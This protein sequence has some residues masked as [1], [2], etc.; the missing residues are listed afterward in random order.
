MRVIAAFAALLTYT[1]AADE[2]ADPDVHVL[3]NESFDEFVNS[4]KYVLAEFYAPW[5]GHCKAL[6][7]EYAKVATALKTSESE[8][9][10]AKIDATV[11]K[12]IAERF[13]VSG[14]PSLF[15]FVDGEKREYTGGRTE[16]E[17][18]A[19]INR[20]TSDPY[21][22]GDDIPETGTKALVLL[23][24]HK[25]LDEFVKL[26]DEMGDD[27][28]FHYLHVADSVAPQVSVQ[29]KGEDVIEASKS[30]MEDL[31]AFINAN[32]LAKFGALDG[33]TYQKYMGSGKGLVWVMLPLES[34][35]DLAAK[36]DEIRPAF[37]ELAGKLPDFKFVYID[38]IM[39]AKAIEGMFGVS[40]FPAVVVHKKAG[41]KKKFVLQGDDAVNPSKVHSFV[42]DVVAGK[43]SAVLKSEDAPEDDDHPVKTIVGSTMEKE[44][45]QDK[46]ILFEVYAPWCGH[47]KK[48]APELDK[49]AS[50]I[51]AD[52]LEDLIRITKMD[53]TANDSPLESIT[54]EGFPTMYYIK[55]GTGKAVPFS[56]GRDAKSIWKWIKSNHSKSGELTERVSAAKAAKEAT[57]E[58]VEEG[59]D[60]L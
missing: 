2:V 9:K 37:T 31:K 38:T 6:A 56:G 41:D 46:D 7:P 40:A 58:K 54:W 5:C 59:K 16:P 39:F 55:A 20:K 34:S 22:T 26:A 35:V 23:K 12:E 19:W 8:V 49:L 50:K 28:V 11:E 52:G 29:H 15:W 21:T 30:D 60:E 14:Y 45:F 18:L 51:R 27:V 3:T 43:V 25:V 42:E 33:A 4:N 10:L 13:G 17:I 48:L 36:V 1:S 57:G 24:A 44:L 32:I 53:G 47:C